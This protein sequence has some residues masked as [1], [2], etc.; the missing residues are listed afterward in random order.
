[1]N[2]IVPFVLLP[3][4]LPL[5][6]EYKHWPR[7]LYRP[8]GKAGITAII[9]LLSIALCESKHI[10]R[11]SKYAIVENTSTLFFAGVDSA[12]KMLAGIMSFIFFTSDPA[13]IEWPTL[14]AFGIVSI[15]VVLLYLD[16]RHKSFLAKQ[17]DAGY[18]VVNLLD[19]EDGEP[20][21]DG[22]ILVGE[23]D[24]CP[25]NNNPVHRVTSSTGNGIHTGIG[26]M[27]RVKSGSSISN[28]H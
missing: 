19:C 18:H 27:H 10:D 1:V 17:Q 13:Q 6:G 23:V 3:F 21:S 2:S 22:S 28:A 12:M 8:H 16:K 24:D 9:A 20:Q 7:E 5:T 26:G 14:L 4:A 25:S 11:F 15:A